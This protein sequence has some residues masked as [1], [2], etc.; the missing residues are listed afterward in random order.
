MHENVFSYEYLNGHWNLWGM[1]TWAIGIIAIC[2][3]VH[4]FMITQKF[5]S[6]EI[7]K[8]KDWMLLGV[9]ILFALFWLIMV[10]REWVK[11]TAFSYAERLYET[12]Q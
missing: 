11:I 9:F 8:T 7:V 2:I 4:S 3:L 10:N 12:L 5:T 1:K 6:I